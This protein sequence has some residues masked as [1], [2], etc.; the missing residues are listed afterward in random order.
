M[1]RI[2]IP[3]V[4]ITDHRPPGAGAPSP[5]ERRGATRGGSMTGLD[6]LSESQRREAAEHDRAVA[7]YSPATVEAAWNDLNARQAWDRKDPEHRWVMARRAAL[8][9]LGVKMRE[10]GVA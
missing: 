7:D 8:R 2:R 3:K 9:R 10:R 5:L 6:L 4:R 1:S